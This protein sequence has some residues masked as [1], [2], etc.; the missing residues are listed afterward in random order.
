MKTVNEFLNSAECLIIAEVAQAHDGSLGMAHAFIDAAAKAGADAIKYQTHI[1][2]AESTSLDKWR[3]KFSYQ[4]ET[5]FDYWKRMEFT[6]D[7]WAGLKTHADEKGL[8]FLSSPFSNEAVEMLEKIGMEAWKIASGELG[9]TPMLERIF[10]TRKPVLVSSGMSQIAELDGLTTEL[11]QQNIPFA[12]MQCTSAYPTP[13]E[14]VGLNVMLEFKERYKCPVGLS[15]HSGTVFPGLA[16][17]ALGMNVLELHL[18]LSK[19]MFGPDVIASVDTAELKQLVTGIRFIENMRA[20][21]VVKDDM[22]GNMAPLRDLFTK[23]IV[24]G[25]DMEAGTVIEKKHLAYKKPG[26]GLPASGYKNLIG[27]KLNRSVLYNH[28]FTEGDF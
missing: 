4:D 12:V 24:A 16:G 1:A 6:A 9:N 13:P 3:V 2:D 10:E 28:F 8:I 22:A 27:K 7:Q 21:P 23:S 5:R 14:K 15:D 19:D 25:M 26:T 18:A 17:A 11:K 20:N